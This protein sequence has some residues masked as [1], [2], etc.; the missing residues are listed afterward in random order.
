MVAAAV[1]AVLSAPVAQ[2]KVITVALQTGFTT[3]DP[4]DAVDVLSRNAVKAV[5]EGLFTFDRD[6]RVQP[7]LA[8][9]IEPSADGLSYTVHLRSGIQFSSGEP[10]NAAAVK[11]NIDRVLDPKQALTA[12]GLFKSVKSVEVVDENTVRFHLVKPFS[13]FPNYLATPSVAMLCPSLIERAKQKKEVAA[14]ETCGTGPYMQ[15]RYNPAQFFEV[16]KNPNYWQ[17]GLPKLEGILFRPTPEAATTTAMLATGEADFAVQ[18]SPEQVAALERVKTV[19]VEKIDSNSERQVYINVTKK[20]FTDVRVRQAL[21]YAVNKEALIKVVFRGMG[22]PASGIAQ[23]TVQYSKQYGVWPYDPKKAK[24]LLQEAGYPNGFETTLWSATTNSTDQR[25]VQFLQQQLTQ[26]GIRT[27]VKALESGERARLVQSVKGPQESTMNMVMW[28]FTSQTGELDWVLRGQILSDSWPPAYAN[29]GFYK[30][31]QVDQWIND[32]VA[33]TDEKEKTAIYEKA[34]DQVWQDVPWIF[35]YVPKN[36]YAT[37]KKLKNFYV[38]PN[39]GIEF[40]KAQWV[41]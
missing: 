13:A 11:A 7:G 25:I 28:G 1:A 34:Q 12:R 33:T 26:V 35:L 41:E 38:L 30:N 40:S 2:A 10:F 24:E 37:N 8:T 3:L 36:V 22:T 18:V 20:P 9:A 39:N 16:K 27:Q 6:M 17:K 15:V 5:Y 23:K 21:N 19:S 4:F 32:A 14:Y 31:A 29:L